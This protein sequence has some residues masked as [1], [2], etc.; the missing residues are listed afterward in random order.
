MQGMKVTPDQLLIDYDCV[1]HDGT[2]DS[3]EWSE[4]W[5]QLFQIMATAPAV[6]AG[7]DMV[8]V[9]K[10]LARLMGAKNVNEFVMK[11]GAAKVNMMQDELVRAEAQKGNM[12]PIEEAG[13]VAG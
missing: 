2:V 6:G 1:V 8:R 11:G 12:V 5:I 13:N 9:F 4:Q 10:H 3:G 7:F